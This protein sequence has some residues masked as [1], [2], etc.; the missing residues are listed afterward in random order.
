LR[1]KRIAGF[2]PA[3][4]AKKPYRLRRLLSWLI[5]IANGRFYDRRW[6]GAVVLAAPRRSGPGLAKTAA[7]AL[8][9]DLFASPRRSFSADPARA[10]CG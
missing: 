2:A 7:S 1:Q 9:R 8:G 6:G 10:G 5:F 3:P 4:R